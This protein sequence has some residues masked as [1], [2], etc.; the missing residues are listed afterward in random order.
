MWQIEDL[1]FRYNSDL[2]WTIRGLSLHINSRT[3][4]GILGPNGCGKTTLLDLLA[5]LLKPSKGKIV[6]DSRQLESFSARELS[7]YVAM[8]PQDFSIRFAFTVQQVVEMGRFPFISRL[9][10]PGREDRKIIGQVME[11]LG[12]THLASRPVTMLSGG[13]LQRVAVARALAQTPRALILDEATSNLDIFHSLSIMSVLKRRM[14][15]DGLTIVAAI[16]DVNLAAD[17]CTD[18]VFI[19]N[20]RLEAAGA[21]SELMNGRI[22]SRVYGVNAEACPDA[23]GDGIQISFRLP[24]EDP[25]AK[26]PTEGIEG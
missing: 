7:R 10:G 20:G 26:G 3:F 22:V 1:W 19:S 12:I 14:E 6:F 24:K 21:K 5:G 2:P 13:E 23:F 17:F 4:T 11:E 18:T 9:G 16:H 15:E 25:A 8:V